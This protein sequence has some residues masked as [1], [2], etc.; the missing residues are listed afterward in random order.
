MSVTRGHVTLYTCLCD[1][2]HVQVLRQVLAR[3]RGVAEGHGGAG[4]APPHGQRGSLLRVQG[5][6]P[7]HAGQEWVR[8]LR[9]QHLQQ[10]ERGHQESQLSGEILNKWPKYV[11]SVS[12]I[13]YYVLLELKCIKCLEKDGRGKY[14]TCLVLNLNKTFHLEVFTFRARKHPRNISMVVSIFWLLFPE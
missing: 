4:D 11:Y 10:R 1:T 14:K 9:R 6:L 8:G 13:L 5:P 3:A 7:V 2:W 12:C